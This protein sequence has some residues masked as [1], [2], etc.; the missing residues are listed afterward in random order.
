MITWSE[1]LVPV[2]SSLGFSV[3]IPERRTASPVLCDGN[4]ASRQIS[5]YSGV[6]CSIMSQVNA[7]KNIIAADDWNDGIDLKT[8]QHTNKRNWST[9]KVSLTVLQERCLE[10]R[11]WI[12]LLLYRGLPDRSLRSFYLIKNVWHVKKSCEQ[13]LLTWLS[14][15]EVS[16][17]IYKIT[18]CSAADLCYVKTAV[19]ISLPNE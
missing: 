9:Y 11:E 10:L 3:V 13:S 19:T 7:I 17:P 16:E 4:T 15:P 6:S 12:P 1:I 2:Q 18:A 8:P 5:A 14:L